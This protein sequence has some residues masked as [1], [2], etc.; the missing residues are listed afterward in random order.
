[1]AVF[2]SQ[3]PEGRERSPNLALVQI[4]RRINYVPIAAPNQMA[5][6]D[7]EGLEEVG[8]AVLSVVISCH[9][10]FS[11]KTIRFGYLSS[12]DH[13]DRRTETRHS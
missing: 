2:A 5:V 11:G 1:M 13:D 3:R 7:G 9:W 10:V 4:P 8:L 6:V 12:L